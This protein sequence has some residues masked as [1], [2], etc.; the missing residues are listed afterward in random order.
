MTQVE[1]LMFKIQGQVNQ[2]CLY[3]NIGLSFGRNE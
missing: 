2:F 1:K 3:S